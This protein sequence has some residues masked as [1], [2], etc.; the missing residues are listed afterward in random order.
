MTRFPYV[1]AHSRFRALPS[2]F[3]ASFVPL[4]LYDESMNLYRLLVAVLA[5][6]ALGAH[7]SP[8]PYHVDV[9]ERGFARDVYVVNDGPAPLNV[10]IDL[11]AAQNTG[12]NPLQIGSKFSH[13]VPANSTRFISTAVPLKA[14]VRASFTYSSRYSFGDP[15]ADIDLS[16]T[17]RLPIA[18]GRSGVIRPFSRLVTGDLVGQTL[19]AVEFL[20]PEGTPVVAAREGYV[21]E[22]R[23]DEDDGD[24]TK[25][26]PFGNQVSVLHADGSWTLYG[27][28]KPGSMPVHLGDHVNA[29]DPLGL[30]G[31]PP[32]ATGPYLHMALL[33]TYASGQVRSAPMRFT[34]VAHSSPFTVQSYA[35]YV[36]PDIPSRLPIDRGRP[37]YVPPA[38]DARP[39]VQLSDAEMRLPPFKRAQIYERRLLEAS[40]Y[41]ETAAISPALGFALGG[42]AAAM[43]LVATA[44]ALAA[45]FAQARPGGAVAKFMQR[46]GME[47][48]TS[49]ALRAAHT[50]PAPSV[51]P[52]VL[53]QRSPQDVLVGSVTAADV[54]TPAKRAG[55]RTA[56]DEARSQNSAL[57]ELPLSEA[58]TLA[59]KQLGFQLSRGVP[60]GMVIAGG[61]KINQL[62]PTPI[63]LLLVDLEDQPR[64]ILESNEA[65]S[66][67]SE[68]LRSE[69]LAKG[70]QVLQ[71]PPML[72]VAELLKSLQPSIHADDLVASD[73]SGLDSEGDQ[74]NPV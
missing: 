68:A 44:L 12:F 8:Y 18:D 41:G 32:D 45:N 60:V 43:V 66:N 37:E 29:G 51:R 22:V 55:L 49:L 35:G 26:I 74:L 56:D 30:S 24:M 72:T 46:L 19:N 58:A 3:S 13:F 16:A 50:S 59:C 70:L 4:S 34:D 52:I 33:F 11:Q 7:A 65:S 48:P 1:L 25:R 57:L 5:L 39:S 28:L 10:I 69:I 14:G 61:S 53:E 40:G 2:P 38:D 31:R 23:G 67:W 71:L 63:P 64:Y 20:V 73:H 15:N 36:S 17:Y 47:I 42:L 54:D 6:H 62:P 21:I 27:W 9:R